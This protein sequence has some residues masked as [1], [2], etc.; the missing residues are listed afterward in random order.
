MDKKF[1]ITDFFM[2]ESL[3]CGRVFAGH[4]WRTKMYGCE[5][6]GTSSVSVVQNSGGPLLGGS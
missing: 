1:I 5:G 6:C 4:L 2:R 3:V